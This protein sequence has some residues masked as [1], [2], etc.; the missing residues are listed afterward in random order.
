M[1]P[2]AERLAP[3]PPHVCPTIEPVHTPV[4]IVPILTSPAIV[5]T[6]GWDA[7][8]NVPVSVVAETVLTQVIVVPDSEQIESPTAAAPVNFASLPIVPL[9]VEPPMESGEPF[10]LKVPALL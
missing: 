1:P 8:D 7:V 10:Q 6:F 5:V 4:V 2:V 3:V 9:T